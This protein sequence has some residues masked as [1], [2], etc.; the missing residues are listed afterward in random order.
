[1]QKFKLEPH[2]A[3]GQRRTHLPLPH[4]GGEAL[5]GQRRLKELA[6]AIRISSF[7]NGHV[8]PVFGFQ[9]ASRRLS[10]LR[11]TH[12]PHHWTSTLEETAR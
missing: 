5:A 8:E 6:T 7:E 10:S 2:A 9:V 11:T 1:L 3:T 4:H 12:L